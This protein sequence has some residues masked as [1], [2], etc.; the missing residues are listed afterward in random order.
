[1]YS[2]DQTMYQAFGNT[3][4]ERFLRT[5]DDHSE[6]PDAEVTN[7]VTRVHVYCHGD[8]PQEVFIEVAGFDKDNVCATFDRVRASVEPAFAGVYGV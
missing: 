8:A 5:V 4:S 6:F 2:K 7:G 3:G 1:M